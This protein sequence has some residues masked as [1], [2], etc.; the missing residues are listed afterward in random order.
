MLQKE[1]QYYA[2]LYDVL[3]QI[4]VYSAIKIEK[5]SDVS[6]RPGS[7]VWSQLSKGVFSSKL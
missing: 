4:P 7:Q 6:G 5:L 2:T 3:N 1:S